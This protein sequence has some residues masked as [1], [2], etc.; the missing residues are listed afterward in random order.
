M[1]RHGVKVMLP[2][3]EFL[4]QGGIRDV[5]GWLLARAQQPV[6]L[7]PDMDLIERRLID[8][9]GFAEF[10]FVL[11]EITGKPVELDQISIESFRT[12]RNIWRT[13]FSE[14]GA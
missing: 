2:S 6:T 1:P 8:S 4:E 11:E 14:G 13:F 5:C 10:L 3:T 7:D 9:L 12:L